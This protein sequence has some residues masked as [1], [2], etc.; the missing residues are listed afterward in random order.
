M[1]FRQIDS[2]TF[3]T[4][5]DDLN[6]MGKIAE[7]GITF[8]NYTFAELVKDVNCNWDTHQITFILRGDSYSTDEINVRIDGTKNSVMWQEKDYKIVW[9][10]TMRAE[11]YHCAGSEEQLRKQYKDHEA[12]MC[13]IDTGKYEIDQIIAI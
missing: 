8:F 12:V 6:E 4:R 11:S 13:N 7:E 5:F 1:E 10:K 3:E 2:V 9:K